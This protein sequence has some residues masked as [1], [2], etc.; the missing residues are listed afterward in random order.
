MHG[1]SHLSPDD[2][3]AAPPPTH[4]GIR[5]LIGQHPLAR[6]DHDSE[7]ISRHGS[8]ESIIQNLESERRSGISPMDR[9]NPHSGRPSHHSSMLSMGPVSPSR[10]TNHNSNSPTRHSNPPLSRQSAPI[11]PARNPQMRPPS[12]MRHIKPPPSSASSYL[13]LS[14]SQ[15]HLSP[16]ERASSQI[17]LNIYGPRSEETLL[18]QA[19]RISVGSNLLVPSL[20]ARSPDPRPSPK[21]SPMSQLSRHHSQ[22]TPQSNKP[23]PRMARSQSHISTGRDSFSHISERQGKK[24]DP[25]NL[26]AMGTEHLD[27]FLASVEKI[28]AE[29]EFRLSDEYQSQNELNSPHSKDRKHPGSV[30]LR[31]GRTISSRWHS[32]E[33]LDENK[34]Q[35][36]KHVE[37]QTPAAKDFV[38]TKERPRSR[39]SLGP[40]GFTSLVNLVGPG[41]KGAPGPPLPQRNPTEIRKSAVTKAESL[42]LDSL[43]MRSSACSCTTEHTVDNLEG[44]TKKDETIPRP[45]M[46]E[47]KKTK[48]EYLGSVPID[49]KATDLTSLQVPMK[50]LYLKFI[51]LKNMG[52]QHLPGTMEISETGL[53]VNYIRELHKGVQEI[54]NPFPTIAVWAA[55]KFVH[56]KEHDTAGEIGHKFA[57]LPLIADPD[58]CGK[59]ELFHSL[60]HEEAALAAGPTHPAMFAAVMRKAGVP[61]QLECHGFVCDSP[62]EAILVAANLYQALLETMKRNKRPNSSSQGSQGGE[63][64]ARMLTSDSEVPNRPPR[65]KKRDGEGGS[66]ARRKSVRSVKRGKSIRRTNEDGS[67]RVVARS[68]LTRTSF[69][70]RSKSGGSVRRVGSLGKRSSLRKT[71]S[72]KKNAQKTRTITGDPKG[73]DKGKGDIYTKVAIPRSKSFMNVSGQYNLQE[74]F[75]ELRE[76]EGIESVDDILR[77]V[78]SSG[79][80]S[81]NKIKPVYREMLMKLV[82]TMSKDEIFIRSQNIMNEQKKKG[83]SKPWVNFGS[84]AAKEG[85]L[86]RNPP[87]QIKGIQQQKKKINKADIGNPV[88]ISIPKKFAVRVEDLLEGVPGH[89]GDKKK[90]NHNH[91][92]EDPYTSCSECGYQSLCGSLCSCSMAGTIDRKKEEKSAD[93]SGCS[94]CECSECREQGD[95]CYSCSIYN[96]S[97]NAGTFRSR[98]SDKSKKSEEMA[99]PDTPLTAWRNNMMKTNAVDVEDKLDMMAGMTS[100]ALPMPKISTSNDQSKPK[101]SNQPPKTPRSTSKSARR[102][103]R[104]TIREADVQSSSSECPSLPRQRPK[105]RSMSRER[106]Q[107]SSRVGGSQSQGSRQMTKSKTPTQSKPPVQHQ[108]ATNANQRDLETPTAVHVDGYFKNLELGSESATSSL[109]R[110]PVNIQTKTAQSSTAGQAKLKSQ[111][112]TLKSEGSVSIDSLSGSSAYSQK[113]AFSE[114]NMQSS[115][116]YLP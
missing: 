48:I 90:G 85:K 42:P 65:K 116:G 33:S 28:N 39:D 111:S 20:Q 19:R 43:S 79:G 15:I 58:D 74:L 101:A 31:R 17:S 103:F 34:G 63:S 69:K 83:K 68:D 87:K 102:Q 53:K 54:F 77:E 23:G 71:G 104:E 45:V 44:N 105:H 75:K 5:H 49:N 35:P 6:W 84:K 18:D 98:H 95:V 47:S 113:I 51:D 46:S 36:S 8:M 29:T 82:M 4:H 81:F 22:M 52:H 40:R 10:H 55:V 26:G 1:I 30:N 114:T 66:V 56:K 97:S 9:F 107:A 59:T 112:N 50:N 99:A 37:N 27:R 78:I 110:K 60:T 96:E 7:R 62:E 14:Q 92:Q 12:P 57:F 72:L 88:P 67:V 89:H 2:L 108:T 80:M 76:K 94:S 93:S 16:L 41:T 109:A 64:S 24:G 73:K 100:N 106:S 13:D 25:L 32:M 86:L 21:P 3:Q 70:N 61:K 38:V 115:L 91:N 11:S